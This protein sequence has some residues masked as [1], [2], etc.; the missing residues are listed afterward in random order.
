MTDISDTE[1]TFRGAGTYRI[2]VQ[3]QLG[4]EWADRLGGLRVTSDEE[5]DGSPSV[6]LTGPIRDQAALMGVL[7][8]LYEL[9]LPILSVKLKN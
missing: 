1:A 5:P 3:G 4:R 6:V 8:T 2:R 7:N 9:H